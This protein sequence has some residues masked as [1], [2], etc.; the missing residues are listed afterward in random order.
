MMKYL[1]IL[2]MAS[3]V[4]GQ[5]AEDAESDTLTLGDARTELR[6]LLN[7]YGSSTTWPD[8]VLNG[9]I[10]QSAW[11]IAGG[12]VIEK[13]DTIV[14][15]ADSFYYP[16][17]AD[18]MFMIKYMVKSDGRWLV[19]GKGD[20]LGMGTVI[21]QDT[22]ITEDDTPMYSLNDDFISELGI[23]LKRDTR[24]GGLYPKSLKGEGSI[25]TDT[26]QETIQSY[27]IAGRRLFIDPPPGVGGDTLI[28][29]YTA[30]LYFVSDKRIVAPAPVAGDSV[31]IFYAS[32]LNTL[33]ADAS[34]V[35]LPYEYR[36]QL[37]QGA[38]SRA[39][40]SNRE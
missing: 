7:D 12:G 38:A 9:F 21:K 24:W 34:I 11:E 20:S 16:L 18:F 28:V 23:I 37:L 5:I 40:T 26:E 35:N 27:S 2:L 32:Y 25:G 17:I 15:A 31:I 36:T 8:S 14:I 22:I 33:S 30:L 13:R 4:F 1:I 29:I 19:F 6:Y 3:P 10:R 39:K